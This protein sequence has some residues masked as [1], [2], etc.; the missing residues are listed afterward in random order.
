MRPCLLYC[1]IFL[2]LAVAACT[3][4]P[5]FREADVTN[6]ESDI[7]T[8]FERKGFLVEQ[9]SM[10]KDS[11]RQLSGFVKM[12]KPGLLLG[13]IELPRTAPRRW[14]WIPVNP[15]GNASRRTALIQASE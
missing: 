1:D 11:N 6:T 4:S 15:S 9:V 3:S 14:I 7:R 8:Q 12:R 10:V 13:K 5:K 2:L